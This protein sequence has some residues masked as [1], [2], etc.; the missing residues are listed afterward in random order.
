M[1]EAASPENKFEFLPPIEERLGIHLHTSLVLI[2]AGNRQFWEDCGWE[3]AG[4]L[5]PFEKNFH[6]DAALPDNVLDL[7]QAPDTE[8]QNIFRFAYGWIDPEQNLTGYPPMYGLNGRL[9][10]IGIFKN[11][12][13][14][15]DQ[16]YRDRLTAVSFGLAQALY[17]PQ[18]VDQAI[19]EGHG[20]LSPLIDFLKGD[21]RLPQGFSNPPA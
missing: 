18:E 1:A 2:H 11:Q 7:N 15:G 16:A 12:N 10:H 4:D 6:T 9:Y 19:R 13:P 20:D 21:K 14:E 3:L 5:G 8:G 17:S